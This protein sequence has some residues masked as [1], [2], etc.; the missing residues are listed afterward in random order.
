MSKQKHSELLEFIK[1]KF[2]K[3]EY[4]KARLEALMKMSH[5]ELVSWAVQHDIID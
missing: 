3:S 1:Y 2:G 5:S 4:L